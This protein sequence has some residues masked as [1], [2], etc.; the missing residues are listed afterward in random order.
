MG[1]VITHVMSISINR[2]RRRCLGPPRLSNALAVQ[3]GNNKTGIVVF[4]DSQAQDAQ[5]KS[6][7]DAVSAKAWQ[8][9]GF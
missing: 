9:Q 7:T 4:L 1:E 6:G 3:V 8:Q 5:L 2:F